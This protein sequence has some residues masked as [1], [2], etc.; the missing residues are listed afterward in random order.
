MAVAML[1]SSMSIPYAIHNCLISEEQHVAV[2]VENQHCGES[3]QS[4]HCTKEVHFEKKCCMV[5]KGVMESNIS[6]TS[7]QKNTF[8]SALIFVAAW[9]YTFNP[10]TTYR[11]PKNIDYYTDVKLPEKDILLWQQ[12]FRC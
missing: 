5:N 11:S 1:L 7:I 10:N 2:F 6:L 3:N 8:Q 4:L 12:V 9:V